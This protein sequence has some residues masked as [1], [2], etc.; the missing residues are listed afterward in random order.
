MI[1]Y[2]AIA[3]VSVVLVVGAIGFIDFQLYKLRNGIPSPRWVERL[4]ER[5]R[6]AKSRARIKREIDTMRGELRRGR[7]ALAV[8][9]RTGNDVVLHATLPHLV[10][11]PGIGPFLKDVAI[12]H[13]LAIYAILR[14]EQ[15][16]AREGIK[17][18]QVNSD[19]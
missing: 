4:D 6:E 7:R 19:A 11:P 3:S 10:L 14:E 2:L 1:E 15:R 9:R 18:T 16:A 13:A 5:I 17:T 8:L 12:E